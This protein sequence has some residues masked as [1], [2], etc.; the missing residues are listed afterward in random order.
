MDNT[1]YNIDSSV[2]EHVAALATLSPS[3]EMLDQAL[4]GSEYTLIDTEQGSVLGKSASEGSESVVEVNG[5]LIEPIAAV[6]FTDKPSPTD[7][8]NH[9]NALAKKDPEL[10]AKLRVSIQQDLYGSEVF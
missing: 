1:D 7:I 10:S 6:A 9:L 4:I 3:R 2:T 8:E 5:Q